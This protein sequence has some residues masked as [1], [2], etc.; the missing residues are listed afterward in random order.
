[1]QV[2]MGDTI[3][4]TAEFRTFGGITADPE[5]ITVK[6]MNS[7]GQQIGEIIQ[8]D[9]N[10]RV[11]SGIYLYE[12]VVPN[13]PSTIVYEFRGLINGKPILGRGELFP[14]LVKDE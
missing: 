1:M 10:S 3:K 12:Y 8:L 9:S 6:F 13:E 2:L 11:G 4:L 5:N 14:V 7:K